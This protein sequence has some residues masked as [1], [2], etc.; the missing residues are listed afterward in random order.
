[1]KTLQDY[2]N[3]F[4]AIPDEK[5][6]RFQLL[7]NEGR[8]CARGHLGSRLPTGQ[9]VATEPLEV[10]EF[11]K[12]LGASKWIV[13]NINDGVSVNYPQTTPKE[14]ILAFIKDKMK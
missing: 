1:M 11:Y 2:Y 5:W 13:T 3:F 12:L 8:S 9:I 7:D 6:C 4:A 10:L 14:R